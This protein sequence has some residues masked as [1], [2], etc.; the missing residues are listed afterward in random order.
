M[1]RTGPVGRHAIT[2][3]CDCRAA[4]RQ[5]RSPA[6][7]RPHAEIVKQPIG[8]PDSPKHHTA[9][10]DR[11]AARPRWAARRNFALRLSSSHQA[12]S[13]A[14]NIAT[15]RGS[16]SAHQIVPSVATSR[17][18]RAAVRPTSLP[19]TPPLRAATAKQPPANADRPAQH[20]FPPR[21]RRRPPARRC[22]RPQRPHVW[23]PTNDT[24]L[25][26]G[27]DLYHLE[28][29]STFHPFLCP[30]RPREERKS[31]PRDTG[32]SRR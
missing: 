31:S 21:S 25:T 30:H 4:T 18:G 8:L 19:G 3:R 13:I 29:A 17:R 14:R 5:V 10:C 24:P 12:S 26:I 22:I 16:Q 15:S 27:R 6:T 23:R 32:S 20:D 1:Q 7:S 28:P 9:P 2:S 11:A